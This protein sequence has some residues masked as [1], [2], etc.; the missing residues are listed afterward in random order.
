MDDDLANGMTLQRAWLGQQFRDVRE[1]AQ[2]R[3]KELNRMKL[4]RAR[5]AR[6]RVFNGVETLEHHHA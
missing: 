1:H 2:G 3:E 5:S 4:D 6:A